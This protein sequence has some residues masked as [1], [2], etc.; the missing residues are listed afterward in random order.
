MRCSLPRCRT[1]S[2]DRTSLATEHLGVARGV[3]SAAQ[4]TATG[5]PQSTPL[6][7]ALG[8]VLLAPLLCS[9]CSCI[10]DSPAPRPQSPIMGR[11]VGAG[12]WHGLVAEEEGCA[13][14]GAGD[15][16]RGRAPAGGTA[17]SRR[18]RDAQGPVLE[19]PAEGGRQQGRGGGAAAA[20]PGIPNPY[21]A[22]R[23]PGADWGSAPRSAS[24][25]S[26]YGRRCGQSPSVRREEE[27]KGPAA[28]VRSTG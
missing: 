25:Q 14:S 21:A 20:R 12:G 9:I 28:D 7:P 18:R 23:K 11:S 3:V 15:A 26:E 16:S 5:E 2:N 27:G 8:P 24:R 22:T 10:D 19:M 6:R 4:C 1:P 13:G 17:L